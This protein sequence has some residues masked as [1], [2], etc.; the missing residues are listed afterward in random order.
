MTDK[1]Y[2]CEKLIKDN[3]LTIASAESCTGGLI[4]SAFVSIAGSSEWFEE[5]LVTY[6]VPSK[7][8]RLGVLQKTVDAHSVVSAQIAEEMAVGVRKNLNTKI[9][10]STTGYAGP[11][12]GDSINPVGTVFVGISILNEV[13][14]KK[15]SLK[16][17]RN[18]IR[19]QAVN[20]AIDFLFEKLNEQ[21]KSMQE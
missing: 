15:L 16:G 21:F 4:A 20:A 14:S 12:G 6:T 8:S 5:G 13:F 2:L 3:N 18:E 11:G 10:I 9:G 1:L 19:T 17:E 7:V